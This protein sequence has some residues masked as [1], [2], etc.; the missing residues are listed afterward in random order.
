MD[1]LPLGYL[2]RQIPLLRSPFG[3]NI[4]PRRVVAMRRVGVSASIICRHVVFRCQGRWSSHGPWSR[5]ARMRKV[6]FKCL[7]RTWKGEVLKRHH[8]DDRVFDIECSSAFILIL[9]ALKTLQKKKP[10][11]WDFLTAVSRMRSGYVIKMRGDGTN[12][13]PMGLPD[14]S[15]QR[16]RHIFWSQ[17]KAEVI[18]RTFLLYWRFMAESQNWAENIN[19]V[20]NN[21]RVACIT[22]RGTLC[23]V[24]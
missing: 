4:C 12:P 22:S 11:W 7:G 1:T 15:F 2:L 23:N 5:G 20:I 14:S 17:T 3:E 24:I 13:K 9:A 6:G 16:S 19:N 10:E 21:S 8:I 18:F